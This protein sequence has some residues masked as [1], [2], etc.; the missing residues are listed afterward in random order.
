MKLGVQS[1]LN[2]AYELDSE[3]M[4]NWMH[5]LPILL[6]EPRSEFYVNFHKNGHTSHGARDDS[7]KSWIHFAVDV[8]D[9]PEELNEEEDDA[10]E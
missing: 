8:T 9:A 1:V 3:T 6:D 10:T 2:L 5:T 7:T 4:T